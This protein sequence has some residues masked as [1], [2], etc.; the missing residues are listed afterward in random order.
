MLTC[1]NTNHR[2]QSHTPGGQA[3]SPRRDGRRAS[4][5]LSTQKRATQVASVWTPI[6]QML[7]SS[8]TERNRRNGSI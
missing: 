4:T 5:W 3:G 2:T 6:D 7:P 1:S 8:I